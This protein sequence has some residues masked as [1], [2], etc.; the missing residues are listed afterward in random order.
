MFDTTISDLEKRK[1]LSIVEG[2]KNNL[3]RYF[4]ALPEPEI[5][6]VAVMD[7]REPF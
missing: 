1:L 3:E 5:V 2:G 4:I 6:E 7:M